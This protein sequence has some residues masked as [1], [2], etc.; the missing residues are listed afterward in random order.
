[1]TIDGETFIVEI[2][3]CNYK[4]DGSTLN[5]SGAGISFF[6]FEDEEDAVMEYTVDGDTL[7]LTIDDDVIE[8]TKQ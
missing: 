6:D 7:E 4:A 8:L 3:V 5:F 2:N 1:M